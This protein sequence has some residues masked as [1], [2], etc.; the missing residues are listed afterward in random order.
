VLDV[1]KVRIDEVCC[2]QR[3]IVMSLVVS[4]EESGSVVRHQPGADLL[5][6]KQIMGSISWTKFTIRTTK[7]IKFAFPVGY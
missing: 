3:V 7:R 4:V 5:S 2:L 6:E 1:G